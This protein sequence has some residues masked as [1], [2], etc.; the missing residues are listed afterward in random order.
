MTKTT[1]PRVN[2]RDTPDYVSR[3][4]P[5]TNSSG[6][7]W[8]KTYDLPATPEAGELPLEWFQVLRE[9]H[10]ASHESHGRMYIVYSYSTPIGWIAPGFGWVVP[11]VR[12]STTTSKHQGL[13]R[14]GVVGFVESLE[15]L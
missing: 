13:V 5:F 2:A 8:A 4:E 12:H 14:R 11:K 10:A 9:Q 15:D 6:S 3:S 7:L 1:S